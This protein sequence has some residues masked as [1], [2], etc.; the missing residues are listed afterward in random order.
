MPGS[1]LS[2][3][4]EYLAKKWEKPSSDSLNIRQI[5]IGAAE[6]S[7]GLRGITEAEVTF[8]YPVSVLVGSNGSGKTT[9][10]NLAALAFNGTGEPYQG[11]KFNDFFSLAYKESPFTGISVVWNFAGPN[12]KPLEIE[13]KSTQKWMHYER[14]PIRAVQFVGVSRIA[15]PTESPG[16]KRAFGTQNVEI[17]PLN[18]K[19]TGYLSQV[20]S[21]EYSAAETRHKGRYDLPQFS[22]AETYSGFNMGTG[23]GAAIAIIKALQDIPRG[24]LVL[25]EEIELGLHPSAVKSLAKVLIDV[26]KS[27]NLQIICT[28]HSEWFIDSLPRQARILLQ[29]SSSGIVRGLSGVTTRTA[30]SGISG[31]HQAELRLVCEDEF[32]R[33]VLKFAIPSTLRTRISFLPLGSKEQLANSAATLSSENPEVPILIVWDS[34]ATDSMIL[35]SHN[36]SQIEKTAGYKSVEWYRLPGGV[37]ANRLPILSEEGLELAPE[38]AIKATLLANGE[39]LKYSAT[40]LG[41]GPQ[42]LEEILNSSIIGRGSHHDLFWEIHNQVS[43]DVESVMDGLIRGY[44]LAANMK[45]VIQQLTRMLDGQFNGFVLPG[46]DDD[47][48]E[49]MPGAAETST[50][51]Q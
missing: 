21:R 15:A 14:R 34:D 44:L 19:Y 6:G 8:N 27:K 49:T 1:R 39:A 40:Y 12:V 9:I 24:G 13:R 10:L 41:I 22:V 38:K 17:L 16:H 26:A 23:E 46:N 3:N 37:D 25:V 36:S 48:S 5:K 45:P 11:Y 20:F 4:E 31:E 51:E 33:R 43:L 50:E 2:N 18:A 35:G 29:R 7:G 42:E 28:S 30:V 47:D 32:A